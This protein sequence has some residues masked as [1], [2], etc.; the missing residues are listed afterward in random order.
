MSGC[1]SVSDLVNPPKPVIVQL[2]VWNR[3]LDPIFVVDQNGKRL[4]VP[5]CGHAIGDQFQVNQLEV[6]TERGFYFGS[7]TSGAGDANRPQVMVITSTPGDSRAAV[8]PATLPP[9]EGHPE[10]Q[11]GVTFR[12]AE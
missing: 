4:D 8:D 1:T 11:P 12:T 6:R 3:T 10:V 5:A 2:Q 9:C 7:G